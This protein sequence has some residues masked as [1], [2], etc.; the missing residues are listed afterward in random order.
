VKTLH[1]I[2]AVTAAIVVSVALYWLT[3]SPTDPSADPCLGTLDLSAAAIS[4]TE[5][6]QAAL[7]D[8]ALLQRGN[9]TKPQEAEPQGK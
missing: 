9:C 7:M 5:S 2:T 8:N 1:L 4:E 6:D 3:L